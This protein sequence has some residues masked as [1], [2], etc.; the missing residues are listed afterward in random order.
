MEKGKKKKNTKKKEEKNVKVGLFK[1]VRLEL[2]KVTW[3]SKKDVFK[4]S[5]A[6]LV[7][8]VVVVLFF[9]LL[10]LGLSVVKGVFN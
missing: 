9:Q 8:C 10:N 3:P 6:T 2:K 1:G 4:Y 5:V 7:F